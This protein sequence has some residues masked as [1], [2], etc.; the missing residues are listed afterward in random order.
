MTVTL[1]AEQD[2][3][4]YTFRQDNLSTI[5]DLQF[6]HKIN[7]GSTAMLINEK[8]RYKVFDHESNTAPGN[9][10]S[11]E[12]KL[13]SDLLW[14]PKQDR[15]IRLESSLYQD[16]RTGLASTI[17][18][19]ALLGGLRKGETFSLFLGGR[20][21]E[22]YG[23]LD[24]GW[25]SEIDINKTWQSESQRS[26][27]LLSGYRDELAEHLNH[28]VDTKMDYM[29]RFGNISSLQ[30]SLQVRN[31]KQEF[32]TDSLGSSQKRDNENIVWQNHFTYK[33]DKHLN[34]FHY[35]TWGDELTQISQKRINETETVS[36]PG[37]ERKRLSLVNETGVM[38]NKPSFTS[39]TAFKVENSQNKYFIDYTQILYQLREN[40]VWEVPML[41]DSLAWKNTLSR[42]EYD[43][44]DT[45][46]D[47]DRDEWRFKTDLS[48]IWQ[49]SP[50]YRLE[51]G[52][53]LSLFHLIY[54]FNTR[55]SENY[56]NRNLVL[57]TGFK[58]S[59]NSWEGDGRA[60]VRSNYFDYDY[61]DLF[62]ETDQPTRSF[63]HRSL[64]L[65]KQLS[66]QI[67]SRW[68]VV[69]RV[70]ARWEDE[71]QL[72]WGA[73]VQQVSSEREQLELSSRLDFDYMD[74][75]GW[76][77]Y[78]THKRTTIYSSASREDDLWFGEGPL[79]GV[80]HALGS[81]LFLDV[82]ARFIS[83][84]DREREYLLPKVYVSLA[85]K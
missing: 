62:L 48:F 43:T 47:D 64:D 21:V 65:R 32:F 69:S 9:Q 24:Q 79:L 4:A 3:L 39:L 6:D 19:W 10:Y 54:I 60:Q 49:P 85:Y 12:H 80:R 51:F 63:V 81:R 33:L 38:Y 83:V 15:S 11:L 1:G 56:W 74:W 61:D 42:L 34:L 59:R 84:N 76:I 8:L 71:G 30:S 52:T 25:G 18:N 66:Y 78:L 68:S 46:N 55:S 27:I 58:W 28:Q 7:M 75:K 14:G 57:W 44:P 20:S 82:D 37:E 77:G 16:H 35:L 73:F 31:R 23:I 5:N 45:N 67:N 41:I 36:L 22:R 17:K 72:D 29:I 40:L 2:S 53:K 26:A 70:A 13:R 50:F